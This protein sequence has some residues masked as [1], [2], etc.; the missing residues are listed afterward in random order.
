MPKIT[1]ENFEVTHS[2][3]KFQFSVSKFTP[4]S[5]KPVAEYNNHEK[6]C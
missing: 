4:L 6:M 5:A 1:S 2:K 3:I